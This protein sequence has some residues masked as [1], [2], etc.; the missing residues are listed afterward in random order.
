MKNRKTIYI[1]LFTLI[2]GLFFGWLI[3]GSSKESTSPTEQHDHSE[4][5]I[6]TCSMH[7]QIRSQESG[8]CPIC[9][10]ELIPLSD[11]KNEGGDPMEIKMSPTAMQLASVQ[12]SIVSK[13]KPIKEVRMNGKVKTDE[14]KVYSQS[15]HIP[16]R[17]E[18]LTVNFTGESIQKGQVLA[19]IYSPELVAAQ[20]ELFE[21]KKIKEEQPSL[22]KAAKEKLQNWKLTDKQINQIIERETIQEQF[23]I[24]ADVSGIVTK[25]NINLGDYIKKGESLYEIA[26]ISTV[27]VLFDVYESDIPWVKKGDK[28]EFTVRSLPNETFNGEVSFIDPVINSKTRVASARVI[29]KNPG[30]RLKPDMFVR[31]IVK[32][33]LEQQEKVIVVPKSA[34]MWTGERSLVYVKTSSSEQVS[35]LMRKVTLGSSLGDSY[36]IKEGLEVGEEIATNGTFSIDAA[37]QLAGKPSMMSPEGGKPVTGHN[38]GGAS[39]SE[40][41]TMEEMSIG[42][43]EKDALSPLFEAYFKLKNNL[44]NDDF[45]AG[46]SSAKEMTTILNKVDMKIFKGEAHDFWMKRSDVL[47]KELKKAISTKEIGELRKPFE[48]I[49]NQLIMILKSF[50]AMD[51]AIYIE[52]CPMVNNNNGADWLS[53][54]S[55][56]KNPYYGEA[57]LKCGEVKQVIK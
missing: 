34:V 53:L 19:Y 20:E 36:I 17:I 13:Q 37:A 49:S 51:K 43:K 54:E 40:T 55:E 39:H 9:G 24:L 50:G 56:I 57:M 42:Q 29:I 22:Y 23:P 46:I 21:A 41:M 25:K 3:F 16:G 14:R 27:W 18:R 11:D 33:E 45:K 52:H 5:T 10:M 48:E 35:F 15:S 31:G 47:S 38:H 8:D 4:E 2:L 32:S 1:A 26:D 28:V 7:P 44:V 12:T 30:K 6:W